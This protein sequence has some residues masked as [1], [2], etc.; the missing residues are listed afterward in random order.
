MH[1]TLIQLLLSRGTPKDGKNWGCM[2]FI[3]LKM[4]RNG[5]FKEERKWSNIGLADRI[6]L[7]GVHDLVIPRVPD[8]ALDHILVPGVVLVRGRVLDLEVRD[9]EADQDPTEADQILRLR[10][11]AVGP[12]AANHDQHETSSRSFFSYVLS[13]MVYITTFEKIQ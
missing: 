3:K 2:I 4:L 9:P 13:G 6:L 1:F 11:S 7:I 10:S 12:A 8:L 5:L